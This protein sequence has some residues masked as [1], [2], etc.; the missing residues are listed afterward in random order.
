MI[1]IAIRIHP[2]RGGRPG[3]DQ[4]VLVREGREEAGHVGLGPPRPVA[5]VCERRL[6]L[7]QTDL[8][9]SVLQLS[10]NAKVL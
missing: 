2:D 6:A 8:G 3:E 4:Q 1:G 7:D 5:V 10:E 9:Q